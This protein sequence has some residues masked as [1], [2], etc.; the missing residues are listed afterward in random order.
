MN[1]EEY[2]E[3]MKILDETTNKLRAQI[4]DFIREG[5]TVSDPTPINFNF[6]TVCEFVDNNYWRNPEDAI[7]DIRRMSYLE[8]LERA[9]EKEVSNPKTKTLYKWAY[10]DKITRSWKETDRWMESED[11][12]KNDY[13][14]A[15]GE[16]KRLDYTAIE[17]EA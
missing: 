8:M 14:W 15:K 1:Y 11:D 16:Y 10:K 6:K 2:K 5:V 9:K 17:V 12:F 3:R 4:L 13:V 7:G